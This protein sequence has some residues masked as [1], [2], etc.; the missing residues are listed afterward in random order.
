MSLTDQDKEKFNILYQYIKDTP[1]PDFDDPEAVE[2]A[3]DVQWGLDL[4]N[5]SIKEVS[6]VINN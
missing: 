5:Q 6:K 2:M 4:I 1:I 3:K